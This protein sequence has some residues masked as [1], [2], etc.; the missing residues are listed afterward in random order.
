MIQAYINYIKHN[1][2]FIQ[3]NKL[4]LFRRIEHPKQY[5]HSLMIQNVQ[6]N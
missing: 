1:K 6:L 4:K 3:K 5:Y 2:R